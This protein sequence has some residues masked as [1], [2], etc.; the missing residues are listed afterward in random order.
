LEAPGPEPLAF[1]DWLAGYRQGLGL[2]PAL[3]LP[4]PAPLVTAAA[5]ALG[6]FSASPLSPATW[7][8]LRA[9]NTGDP[10][11]AS[12]L[13]GRPLR[14]PRD[15]ISAAER[16]ALRLRALADWRRPLAIG[17]LTAIWLISAL[18]SAGLFPIDASL[19]RLAPF[20]LSGWPALG[21][22]AVAVALDLILGLLTLLRPGKRLWQTQ[23]ALVLAYSL[24]VAWRL[25]DFLLDPFGPILKNLAVLA[26]LLQLWSEEARP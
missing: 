21:V 1:G 19:A 7:A 4:I 2:A 16:D 22:L 25:P 24:L 8:M 18:L 5:W 10:A 14:A 11:P 15:F 3:R 20:G 12:R 26:L 13:L 6:H 23:I 17:V 9:G